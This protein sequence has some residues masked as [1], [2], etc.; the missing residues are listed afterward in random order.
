[1]GGA[2]LWLYGYQDLQ[3]LPTSRRSEPTSG[4]GSARHFL[5]SL[6]C[7]TIENASASYR[8]AR[9]R[10]ESLRHIAQCWRACQHFHF[11]R[12]SSKA[13]R[14]EFVHL[15]REQCIRRALLTTQGDLRAWRVMN[16]ARGNPDRDFS[17]DDLDEQEAQQLRD[18]LKSNDIATIFD[19]IASER[20][21][22]VIGRSVFDPNKLH[23]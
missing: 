20:I 2:A 21:G 5:T 12:C 8:I 11:H 18:L 9:N 13:F 22:A 4:I 23:W 16:R 1:M 10:L 7:C 17:A 14:F 3:A 15:C 19:D 6:R